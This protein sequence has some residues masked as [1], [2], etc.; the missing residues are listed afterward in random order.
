VCGAP[1]S[2]TGL[3]HHARVGVEAPRPQPVAQHHHVRPPRLVLLGEEGPPER[4][5][6][7]EHAEEAVADARA[8]HAL[9]RPVVGQVE[10]RAADGRERRE[11]PRLALPDGD[12]GEGRAAGLVVPGL[13]DLDDALVLRERQ[14]AE[15]DGVE[16]AEDGGRGPDAQREHQ[17]R[18]EV[19]GGRA[20]QGARAEGEVL[21]EVGEVLGALHGV[22]SL[23]AD[24]AA[25]ARDALD[26]AEAPECLG[27][28]GLGRHPAAGELAR[29]H[30]E[31]EGDLAVHLLRDARLPEQP[32]EEGAGG[33]GAAGH[34]SA[35]G[36]GAAREQHLG[37][38]RGEARPRRGLP[39]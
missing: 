11:A 35:S 39:L 8:H 38:G 23:A 29:A 14:R 5:P 25:L 2:R 22:I 20:A 16:R 1:L 6:D 24:G 19:D 15:H 18:G 13:R 10:A 27:A 28:R 9:G 3:P 7:A 12:G 37:H 33:A 32:A 17:H 4:R 36:G 30:L 34:G 31:V 21:P 26:G